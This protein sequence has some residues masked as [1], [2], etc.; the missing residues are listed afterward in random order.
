MYMYTDIHIADVEMEDL[1]YNHWGILHRKFPSSMKCQPVGFLTYTLAI[2]HSVEETLHV[3]SSLT[4][5]VHG[6][7]TGCTHVITG[8]EVHVHMYIQCAMCD[9]SCLMYCWASTLHS[10]D[11]IM[12]HIPL[13]HTTDVCCDLEVDERLVLPAPIT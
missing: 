2:C 9:V 5:K 7:Y 1:Q 11:L 10:S 12:T 6:L 4:Y 8:N 3:Y 13:W